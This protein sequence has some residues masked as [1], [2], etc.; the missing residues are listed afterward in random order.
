VDLDGT[1]ID[2]EGHVPEANVRAIAKAREA[3][4][5]VA[6][7]TGRALVECEPALAA[8]GRVDPVIVSGGAMIACPQTSRTL[9]R[10]TLTPAF[11]SQ[12]VGHIAEHDHPAMLLKDP[13]ATGYDYLIVTPDGPEAIDVASKWWFENM[14]VRT[15]W[16]PRL[17]DD[18]HPHDTIRVGAYQANEPVDMLATSLR[19]RFGHASSLQHFQGVVIPQGRRDMGVASIHIIEVFHQ[20]ADKW[21]ALQRLGARLD[22]APHQIA[23]IGD[24]TNDLSMIT[25]AGLGVAMANAVPAVH[26]AAKR[27]TLDA[28]AAG[29]AHAIDQM[30]AGVW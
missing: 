8:T 5:V 3:G 25:H 12:V 13:A 14:N 29:V 21:Q 28:S 10:F 9:E 11:V 17:E 26:A 18:P 27:H 30:L 15:R 16:V 1:L 23:A 24:Q 20:Q 4:V 2:H 19:D 22:I 6:L 7:C